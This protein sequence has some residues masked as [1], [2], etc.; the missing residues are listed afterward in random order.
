MS[1][2]Q[3]GFTGGN[4]SHD[5]IQYLFN[6]V[7]KY[8]GKSIPTLCV[9][10]DLEKAFDIVCYTQLQKIEFRGIPLSLLQSYLLNRK[11]YIKIGNTISEFRYVE[12]GVVQGTI[13][14]PILFSI[15]RNE[16]DSLENTRK[17]SQFGRLHCDHISG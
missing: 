2:K 14:R 11:Q 8:I 10:I 9:F 6:E 16:P 15:N 1:S 7:I 5:A 13:L 4:S 3:F 12:Y 17:Y